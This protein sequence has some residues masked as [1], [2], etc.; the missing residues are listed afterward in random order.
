CP[1][2]L[3]ESMV[4]GFGESPLR[5]A[6][7][8]RLII[9]TVNLSDGE[10]AIFRTPHL[11]RPRPE[12]DW[13]IADI[14]VAAT[15]APTY[16]PHKEMP[17][18]KSYADGGLWAIDPGVAALAEAARI[19]DQESECCGHAEKLG[20]VKMLSIGTGS[21]SYTLAPPGGDAGMLFWAPHVAEVMSI[22]QVQGTQ[23]PLRMVL[24]QRYTHL[25]F[26]LPDASWTLDNTSI[27][28]QLFDM[29]HARGQE[30][31]ES[32]R[33]SFFEAPRQPFGTPAE[34]FQATGES[35]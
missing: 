31:F 8:C 27:T 14:I 2:A 22:S 1:F 32:L 3:R 4:D 26:P 34:S 23:L 24:G 17:D 28:A 5:A 7:R 20:Q 21:A 18:G 29:G 11:T 9:P 16:F 6:D 25:D 10:T 33:P 12:Y 13:T 30:V 35:S 15:A 19:I